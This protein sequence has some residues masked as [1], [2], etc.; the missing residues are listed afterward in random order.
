MSEQIEPDQHPVPDTLRSAAGIFSHQAQALDWVFN[1]SL[2]KAT[3]GGFR[4]NDQMRTALR[5]QAQCRATFKILLAM[6]E[7]IAAE[8]K[9][10]FGRTNYSRR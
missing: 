1:D 4:S 3:E 9:S 7:A 5:A 10:K 6:E 8:K 2:K